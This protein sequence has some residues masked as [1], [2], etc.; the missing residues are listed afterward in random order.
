MKY[1]TYPRRF[2]SG[3]PSA[4]HPKGVHTLHTHGM[5]Y[6][7]NEDCPRRSSSRCATEQRCTAV[8]LAVALI[9]WLGMM[10]IWLA[11]QQVCRS[12]LRRLISSCP[13]RQQA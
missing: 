6:E 10:M 11:T 12:T 8:S 9:S 1:S 4:V 2:A 5:P 13:E 7:V 3:A